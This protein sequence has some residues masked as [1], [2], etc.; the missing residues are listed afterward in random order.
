MIRLCDWLCSIELPALKNYKE[1]SLYFSDDP[2]MSTFPDTNAQEELRYAQFIRDGRKYFELR[3]DI[4]PAIAIDENFDV[5]KEQY[6][7]FF[8][9]T[10]KIT[11]LYSEFKEILSKQAS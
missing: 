8:E 10:V 9:K 5:F 1:S 4:V 11:Y 6:P 3:P 2:Q 7:A